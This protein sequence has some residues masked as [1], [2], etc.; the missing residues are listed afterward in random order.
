M[1]ALKKA[2]QEKKEA[3]RKLKESDAGNTGL[4]V[5][6]DDPDATAVHPTI[7]DEPAPDHAVTPTEPIYQG[8]TLSLALEPLDRKK[9]K[10]VESGNQ[11]QDQQGAVNADNSHMDGLALDTGSGDQTSANES[12]VIDQ[13]SS[14]DND[15]TLKVD[16]EPGQQLSD[17]DMDRTFHGMDIESTFVPGLYE[18]TVQGEPLKTGDISQSYDETLPGVPAAQL[19]R[20]IGS[21]DQPTPVAAQTLF[22]AGNTVARP[23]SGY[24]WLLISLSVLLVGSAVIFYYYSVTPVSRDIPSPVVARGVESSL[25]GESL[26][27][28]ASAGVYQ[29]LISQQEPAVEESISTSAG[30]DAVSADDELTALPETPDAEATAAADVAGPVD[31]PREEITGVT[32]DAAQPDNA[33]V[34]P[35]FLPA[36]IEAPRS[37]IKISRSKSP[38]EGAR[39]VS[40]AYTAW[41][42]GDYALAKNHYERAF[43]SSPDNRDVLLG[44][45]AVAVSEGEMTKAA[46]IYMR[47]LQL[48]PL[49]NVARAAML[50]I[51]QGND[52]GTGISRIKSMLAA[53]TEQPSLHFTL[54]KLYASQQKWAEA[55]QAFFDAYRLDSANPDYAL[56]LA[57]SLDRMGQPGPALDYYKTALALSENTRGGF[58]QATVSARIDSLTAGQ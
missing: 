14:T 28:F 50:G 13:P 48:N 11:G 42:Q 44:L 33:S 49:D 22:T 39:L 36:V 2:E 23:A 38:D 52:P 41:Q 55:Q 43:A 57:V 12:P 35:G 6:A 54:G 58:D 20:D 9:E 32:V 45:A 34:E 18:D 53:D 46:Q 40:E 51:S 25:P 56:N 31:G 4:H 30:N 1:D 7:T 26:D 29:T 24:R 17:V 15:T 47:L 19:A 3:A 21:K 10:A 16:P 8:S 37:L 5:A 27:T